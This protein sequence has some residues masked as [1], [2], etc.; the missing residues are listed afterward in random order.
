MEVEAAAFWAYSCYNAADGTEGKSVCVGTWKPNSYLVT[1]ETGY[2][3][4]FY[5]CDLSEE[6]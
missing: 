1:F 2:S 3:V 6:K 4:L 5:D